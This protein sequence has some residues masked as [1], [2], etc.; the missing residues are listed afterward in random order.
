MVTPT[1]LLRTNK[2][3]RFT[4][5]LD[6]LQKYVP[7]FTITAEGRTKWGGLQTA[8]INSRSTYPLLLI[9]EERRTKWRGLQTALL[10]SRSTYPLLL[11]SEE[12][13]RSVRE[14]RISYLPA[15]R[16]D[17]TVMVDWA[18]N[19]K[20]LTYL[21]EFACHDRRPRKRALVFQPDFRIWKHITA[22]SSHEC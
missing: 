20:L 21:S 17:M 7:T 1:G 9:T 4:N 15:S 13:C 6:K 11:V 3:L 22:T 12:V 16:P 14:R 19:T 5:S 18:S 8:L 2:V 10:N